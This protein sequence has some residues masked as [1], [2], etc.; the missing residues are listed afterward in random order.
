[1]KEIVLILKYDIP[2]KVS[3]NKIYSWMHWKQR[4]TI[5]NMYHD[6][7]N[8]VQIY[9]TFKEKVDIEI[10]FY[11]RSK[12][13]DSSNCSF[14]WKMIEDSLVK[15]KLLTDDTNTYVWKFTVE[16]VLLD[17]KERKKIEKDYLR[18]LITK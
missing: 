18:I 2:I 15:N 3:T 11:F 12:Y 10:L 14:M 4:N 5:A 8:E 13:L 1:M 7:T 17:K 6:L 9:E 16:S